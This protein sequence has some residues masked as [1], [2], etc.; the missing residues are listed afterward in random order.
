MPRLTLTDAEYHLLAALHPREWRG[1]EQI[2]R[3]R[4][5]GGGWFRGTEVAE[6]LRLVAKGWVEEGPD[7]W[8]LTPLG[9]ACRHNATGGR[10]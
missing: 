1:I 2:E 3:D 6:L 7:G 8:R 9:A 10:Y 5:V 4:E